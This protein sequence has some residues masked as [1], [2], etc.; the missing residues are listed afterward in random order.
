MIEPLRPRKRVA[1]ILQAKRHPIS[2]ALPSTT[3]ETRTQ[4]PRGKEVIRDEQM[5]RCLMDS[6]ALAARLGRRVEK[7]GDPLPE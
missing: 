7:G 6:R 2:V 3:A 4:H 1:F 5:A